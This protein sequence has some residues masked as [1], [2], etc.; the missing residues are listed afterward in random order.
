MVQLPEVVPFPIMPVHEGPVGF[1]QNS[2]QL[3]NISVHLNAS[4]FQPI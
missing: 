4:F 2:L 1:G 3:M